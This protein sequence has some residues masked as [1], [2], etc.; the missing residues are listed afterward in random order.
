MKLNPELRRQAWIELSA[1]RLVALPLILGVGFAAVFASFRDA[2]AD[3]VSWVALVA[4]GLLTVVWGVRLVAT[5]IVDELI[6]KTWDWQRLSILSPWTM[7]WGKLLGSTL[8]A[9]FGGL[10]CL[11]VFVAFARPPQFPLPWL[12]AAMAVALAVLS[13]ATTLAVVLHAPPATVARHRRSIGMLVPLLALWLLSSG[14]ML[15]WEDDQQVDWYGL[16]VP[17]PG[18]VLGSLAVFAAWAVVGAYRSMCVRLAVPTTPLAWLGFMATLVLYSAGFGAVQGGRGG[19]LAGLAQAGLV[20]G[21]VLCYAMLFSEATGPLVLRHVLR[22]LERR[23]WQRLA[24]ALPCWPLAWLVAAGCAVAV[25]LSGEAALPWLDPGGKALALVMLVARDAA[26]LLGFL[27]SPRP[28]RAAAT[29]VV[30]LLLLDLV[31]PWLLK[32][33]ELPAAV[34]VVM[35]LAQDSA[36]SAFVVAT[37]QALAAGAW[38]RSRL[39]KAMQPSRRAD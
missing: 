29:T 20:W 14:R 39:K 19:L 2:P 23:Q 31:L 38:A 18:F 34:P 37:L 24:Q 3:A 21:V 30:Y 6:D 27:A 15:R 33:V 36:V 9:W 7:T 16:S 10:I 13:Q 1:H 22:R 5:S 28:Q 17:L 12:T 8:F 35:P 26:L 32:A 4:F 25:A 11:A